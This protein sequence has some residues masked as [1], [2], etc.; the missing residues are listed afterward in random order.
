MKKSLSFLICICLLIGIY[1]AAYAETNVDKIQPDTTTTIVGITGEEIPIVGTLPPVVPGQIVI[2]VPDPTLST[3]IKNPIT[4]RTLPQENTKKETDTNTSTVETNK[5]VDEPTNKEEE[6]KDESIK[7]DPVKI[8]AF[9]EE[10]FKLI[11]EER[12]TA[13]LEALNYNME[14][15][16]PADVRA[17]E[18]VAK[19]AHTR[20]DGTSCFTVVKDLDYTCVGENLIKADN[21]IATARRLVNSWMQSE[22]HRANILNPDFTETAIGVFITDNTTYSAELFMG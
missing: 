19:F 22:G 17:I 2:V 15:Q 10:I 5:D 13:G 4:G 18:S 7:D 21:S 8:A 11:N 20:P 9:I 16:H 12:A 6:K 1:V 3:V 14:L